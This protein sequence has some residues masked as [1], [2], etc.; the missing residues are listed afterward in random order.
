M[1]PLSRCHHRQ[2]PKPPPPPSCHLLQPF[3]HFSHPYPHLTQHL[4]H[5]GALLLGLYGW[6]RYLSGL[7]N[8]VYGRHIY[9]DYLVLK[10]LVPSQLDYLWPSLTMS[11][12]SS[13]SLIPNY[14]FLSPYLDIKRNFQRQSSNISHFPSSTHI[15]HQPNQNNLTL[16]LNLPS[17]HILFAFT[18]FIEFSKVVQLLTMF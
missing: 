14:P 10:L 7:T 9:V 13:D 16:L 11:I 5:M 15:L 2:P 6:I 18:L 3:P 12:V 8:L 1:W 4:S 17:C